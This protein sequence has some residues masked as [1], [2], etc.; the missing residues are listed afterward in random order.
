MIKNRKLLLFFVTLA[1]TIILSLFDKDA[2]AVISLYGVYCCGNVGAKFAN[3][4]Q[5]QIGH[6][7]AGE[8]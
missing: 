4:S 6:A 8:A 2:T 5:D 1:A 3:K 7:Y